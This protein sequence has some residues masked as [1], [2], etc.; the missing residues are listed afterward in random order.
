[1]LLFAI[2]PATPPTVA[3]VID[4]PEIETFETLATPAPN[5]T[6]AV[7]PVA[8]ISAFLI[9]MFWKVEVGDFVV[10]SAE[11]ELNIVLL[12]FSSVNQLADLPVTP[13]AEFVMPHS[14]L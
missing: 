12:T 3:P 13:E 1:M 7:P 9:T 10:A 2:L 5:R 4:V 6:P 8:E 14:E 11:V